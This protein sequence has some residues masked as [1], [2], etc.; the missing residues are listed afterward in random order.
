[1]KIVKKI[2]NFVLNFG[3]SFLVL[4]LIILIIIKNTALSKEFIISKLKENRFYERTYN[5]I[6]EDF[7]NYT[8]QSGLEL[9]ILNG[10]ISK[11]KVNRDIDLKIESIFSGKNVEIDTSSIKIEL[12]NR[13]N[14]A[15]EKNNR[16]P[17]D[18]EKKS[19]E[20]YENTIVDCYKNGILY[21][22]EFIIEFN[23]KINL[24]RNI[25]IIGIIAISIILLI[26]NKS[27][28]KYS[29]S[30]GINFL[31]SG[32]L[33]SSIKPLLEGRILN[34]LILDAKF[35]NFFVNT[36]VDIISIFFK[37]GITL[38]VA[39]VALII[40]SNLI[41]TILISRKKELE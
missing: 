12:D 17:G 4:G 22:R 28:L 30:I 29:S 35:S 23:S 31:F 39:G 41:K 13:I 19:I 1:M 40:L 37:T 8:M 26:V 18:E 24:I 36:L 32:I 9:E 21:G 2:I 5:D 3:L 7:E 16:I 14:S 38:I 15:L 27:F 10:L 33:C 11:E 34:I 25:C 6:K 20:L